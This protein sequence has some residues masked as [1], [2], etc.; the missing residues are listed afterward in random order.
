MIQK[1]RRNFLKKAGALSLLGG[2]TPTAP[3]LQGC[4]SIDQ[5]FSPQ[6]NYLTDR[7]VI[8]GGGLAGLSAAY[9]LKKQKIPYC[10]FEASRSCGGRVSTIQFSNK[11]SEIQSL[12]MGADYFDRRHSNLFQLAKE[13]GLKIREIEG[14]LSD[15][16][17][18]NQKVVSSKAVFQ[19]LFQKI[20]QHRLEILVPD[21]LS[22]SDSSRAASFDQMSVIDYIRS[23]Q[24]KLDSGVENCF[25]QIVRGFWGVEPEKLSALQLILQFD[26]ESAQ[27][28][29]HTA[30]R[31][32]IQGGNQQLIDALLSRIDSTVPNYL[33]RLEH[34]LVAIRPRALMYEIVFNTPL[35]EK[36]YFCKKMICALPST[37]LKKIQG[38]EE[39]GASASFIQALGEMRASQHIKLAMSYRHKFWNTPRN[40][41]SFYVPAFK[42]GVIGDWEIQQ[43]YNPLQDQ[44]DSAS[45]ATKSLV[46][47]QSDFGVLSLQVGGEKATQILQ[48]YQVQ[49]KR[50]LLPYW[51][52]SEKN[53]QSVIA[54]TDWGNKPFI[55]GSRAVYQPTQFLSRLDVWNNH[56]MENLLRFAGEHVSA[57]WPGTMEGAV[58]SGK[59]AAASF[60]V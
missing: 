59:D 37:V 39:L 30:Q 54:F 60:R 34:E 24:L 12:E 1:K 44:S 8:L 49:P 28:P 57:A 45:S 22:I 41:N 36:S 13:L 50:A 26:H 38:W 20:A 10:I 25:L 5:Y 51:Q 52:E 6:S 4:S 58:S 43:V 29:F 19:P 17:V 16:I 48:K 32:Q 40:E 15:A 35:G 55:L 53:F 3:L 11:N 18:L 23:L 21:Q 9:E 31:F 7:V 42:G 33:V 2:L 27:F 46:T 47:D 14:S 56:G